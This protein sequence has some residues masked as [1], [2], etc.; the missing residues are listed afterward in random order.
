MKNKILPKIYQIITW[1]FL[2]LAWYGIVPSYVFSI[3]STAVVMG[4]FLISLIGT[5]YVGSRIQNVVKVIGEV[6]NETNN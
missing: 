3:E 6:Q 2:L 5:V 1:V 4:F